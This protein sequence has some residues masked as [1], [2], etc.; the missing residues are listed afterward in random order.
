[1]SDTTRTGLI[2]FGIVFGVAI[3]IAIPLCVMGISASKRSATQ[4]AFN[5]GPDTKSGRGSLTDKKD[6][7]EDHSTSP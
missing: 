3:L 5:K 4:T 6:I 7:V 2:A 1:M